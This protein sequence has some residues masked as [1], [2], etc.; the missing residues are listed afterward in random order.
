MVA[1]PTAER[2]SSLRTVTSTSSP[3]LAAQVTGDV[4]TTVGA[5]VSVVGNADVEAESER[6]ASVHGKIA[7]AADGYR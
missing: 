2:I 7:Q 1:G 5:I 3:P 4:L 6:R